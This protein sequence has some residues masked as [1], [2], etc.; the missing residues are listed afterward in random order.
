MPIKGNIGTISAG[1]DRAHTDHHPAIT[2]SREVKADNGVYPIGLI[3]KED[4]NAELVPYTGEADTG[5]PVAVIDEPCDTASETS[6][7]TLEHG[8]VRSSL[9]KIGA[10]GDSATAADIKKLASCG[11]YAV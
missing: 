7:F 10:D 11:I 6:A 5:T 1:G 2:G 8:T 3:V 9:L 4:E